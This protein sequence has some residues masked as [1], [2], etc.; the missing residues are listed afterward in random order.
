MLIFFFY[1]KFFVIKY[2]FY[3]C[4]QIFLFMCY[5]TRKIPNNSRRYNL[6]HDKLY[7]NVP[8]GKCG[9]CKQKKQ[10][11]TT[12]RLYYQFLDTCS[13]PVPG[14]H[15]QSPDGSVVIHEHGYAYFESFTYNEECC[16]WL[17]GIRV[18]RPSDYR[19]FSV[20]LRHELDRRGYLVENVDGH[21]VMPLKIYWT[22]EFGG[23]TYRPHHHA[24]FFVTGPI[25]PEE[26]EE[27][28]QKCWSIAVK[29]PR[30]ERSKGDIY[31]YVSLGWTDISNPNDHTHDS[32]HQL[33]CDSLSVLSYVANYVG[34]DYDLEFF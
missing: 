33:V 32:P 5:A 9:E 29:K 18:F 28:L 10:D 15:Y 3:L 6:N 4:S 23:E 16:P 19:S 22:S 25:T 17:H 30:S 12:A 20:N 14:F 13:T 21:K 2:I 31:D 7:L 26:L 8:C 11:D 27:I 1:K 24:I 34:K